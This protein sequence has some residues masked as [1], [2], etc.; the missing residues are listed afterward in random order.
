MARLSR[1]N[2]KF[3]SFLSDQLS[4]RSEPVPEVWRFLKFLDTNIEGIL[5]KK[6]FLTGKLRNASNSNILLLSLEPVVLWQ[7]LFIRR[8]PN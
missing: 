1:H 8:D 3:W 7:L 6:E 5:K 4:P 2:L